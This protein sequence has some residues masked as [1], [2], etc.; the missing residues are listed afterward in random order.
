MRKA[1]LHCGQGRKASLHTNEF[2]TASFGHYLRIDWI[3]S[4][5][6]RSVRIDLSNIQI[7]GTLTEDKQIKHPIYTKYDDLVWYGIKN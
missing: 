1:S 3:F 4:S 2:V 7:M 6:R 5:L